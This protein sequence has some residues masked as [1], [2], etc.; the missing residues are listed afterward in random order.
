M[1]QVVTALVVLAIVIVA[2]LLV[3]ELSGSAP[4]A[5]YVAALVGFSIVIGRIALWW[6]AVSSQLLMLLF[7]ALV[8]LVAVRWARDRSKS[9]L[10]LG[11]F[12]Q[13]VAS[14]FSDRASLVPLLVLVVVALTKAQSE[15]ADSDSPPLVAVARG[16]RASL[17]LVAALLL[18][19]VVQ[20]IATVVFAS[21]NT[22][23]GFETAADAS[24]GT[25]LSVVT[26]WWKRGV[27]SVFANRFFPVPLDPETKAPVLRGQALVTAVIG[28]LVILSL[29]AATGRSRLSAIVWVCWIG[30]VTIAGLQVALGRLDPWGPTLLAVYP[31]YQDLTL[32]FSFVLIPFSWA[33]TA[34][35][36]PGS[37]LRALWICVGLL[38]LFYWAVSLR[39]SVRDALPRSIAAATYAQN[40][41][42]SAS[43]IG[44]DR[45]GY[46]LL[47]ERIPEYLRVPVPQYADF[48]WTSAVAKVL[49][50]GL[51]FGL[52]NEV[53]GRPL[54]IGIDGRIEP[55]DA[56]APTKTSPR[57]VC[58]KAR[59][60]AEWLAPNTVKVDVATP[61]GWRTFGRWLLLTV[62]LSNTNGRGRVGVVREG[63]R[64][65]YRAVPLGS[66][67]HGFRMLIPEGSRALSVQLWDG[68]SGCISRVSIN[69]VRQ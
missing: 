49:A 24:A 56:L 34:R 14:S 19:V 42:S 1:A 28:S 46:T 48:A 61:Q 37:S 45:G 3:R 2:A 5:L 60:G 47:D 51:D 68:A 63:D 50:P 38:F 32:L 52:P 29:A 58:G 44:A 12:L 33:L 30:L 64:L 18:V 17:P 27:T 53:S 55:V 62:G 16:I 11:V 20:V 23:P 67:R 8:V 21:S 7:G 69:Q 65:P 41:R 35:T 22:A 6:T 15:I 36:A 25:W 10:V 31:R 66:Y 4:V 57:R 26:E 40:L 43:L 39:I 59:P 54:R 9:L 13:L